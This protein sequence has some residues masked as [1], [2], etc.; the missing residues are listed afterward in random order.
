MKVR[1][2]ETKILDICPDCGNSLILNIC[3]DCEVNWKF[4]EVEVGE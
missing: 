1:E 4:P 3:H 2:Y